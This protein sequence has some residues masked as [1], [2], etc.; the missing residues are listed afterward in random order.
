M[1]NKTFSYTKT[2]QE[3]PENKSRYT[4]S[5]DICIELVR[6]HLVKNCWPKSQERTAKIQERRA[7]SQERS[8]KNR[9]RR[10]K[11]QEQTAK[12]QEPRTKSEKRRAKSQIV[13]SKGL[14]LFKNMGMLKLSQPFEISEGKI[15]P[16]PTNIGVINYICIW[17][18]QYSTPDKGRNPQ[19]KLRL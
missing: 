4:G 17:G 3:C 15:I 16:K 8:A 6:N 19:M 9:E 12:S 1:S 5:Q 14:Q 18:N 10:S 7:R 11:S 2:R 13:I